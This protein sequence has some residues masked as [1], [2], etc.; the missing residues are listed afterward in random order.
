MKAI[1]LGKWAMSEAKQ[2][3]VH[4]LRKRKGKEGWRR[5]LA[6]KRRRATM[7]SQ[8]HLQLPNFVVNSKKVFEK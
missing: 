8:D 6:K 5:L 1:L 3:G 4:R 7:C 2:Y